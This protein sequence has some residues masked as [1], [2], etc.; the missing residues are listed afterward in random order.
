MA[1]LDSRLSPVRD[2]ERRLRDSILATHGTRDGVV[3]LNIDRAGDRAPLFTRLNQISSEWG[4][5][6]TERGNLNRQ[7]KALEREVVQLEKAIINEGRKKR[8]A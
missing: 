1:L 2:E 5:T 3:L 7:I 6:K 8:R 4:P